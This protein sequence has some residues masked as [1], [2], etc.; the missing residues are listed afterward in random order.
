MARLSSPLEGRGIA[1]DLSRLCLQSGE[2]WIL[3]RTPAASRGSRHAALA[4][5]VPERSGSE[6]PQQ[7]APALRAP[8]DCVRGRAVRSRRLQ[9]YEGVRSL[10]FQVLQAVPE[11]EARHPLARHLLDRVA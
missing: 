10:G 11:A 7:A 3:G 4:E 9:R 8:C 1:Y 5:R 2:S 6:S